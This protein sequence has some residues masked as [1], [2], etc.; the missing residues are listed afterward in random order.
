MVWDCLEVFRLQRGTWT[1][2]ELNVAWVGD[3]IIDICTGF[4]LDP[5]VMA[6]PLKRMVER[7][8][9]TLQRRQRLAYQRKKDLAAARDAL[10][11]QLAATQAQ[12]VVSERAAADSAKDMAHVSHCVG[13]NEHIHKMEIELAS[14]KRSK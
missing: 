4:A 1:G 3:G 12:L 7:F 10:Q 6:D 8:T 14:I 11:T 5:A 13:L 2:G 9:G